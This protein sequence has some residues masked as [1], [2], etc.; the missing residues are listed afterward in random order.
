[1]E[2]VFLGTSCMQPTKERN[3]PGF[4][5]SYNAENML[6]DCGEGLQRQIRIAGIKPA[7]IT[8]LFISHWHGDH[9]LG[10]PGLMQTMGASQYAKKLYI[11]GPKE[12][13]SNLTKVL[14]VFAKNSDII[15][16]EVIEIDKDGV[17]LDNEDF[18]VEA[19]TLDH[20]IDT[21]GFKFIEKD[22][23]RILISKIKKLGIKEG[24]LLGKLAKGKSITHKGKKY[25]ADELTSTVPGKIIGYVADT[26][27]TSNCLKIAQDCD[28][29]VSESSF[30]TKHEDKAEQ[31]KHLTAKQAG[32]MASQCNVK[33]LFLTHFSQRYKDVNDIL[34]DAKSVFDEVTLAYD[35]MKI[36]V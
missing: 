4:L 13:K 1:M 14:E 26:A 20:G 24:P 28:V 22:R 30:I 5:V 3:H 18:T 33:K 27:Y 11:Y 9:V 29:L 16:H 7:K 12:T 17:F 15:E 36:K 35:F 34:D 10:I 23:R 6:F 31:Y 2:I 32:L 8:R 21:I 25:S 19:Y